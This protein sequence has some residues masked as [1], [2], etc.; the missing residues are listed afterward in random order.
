MDKIER[1]GANGRVYRYM[2]LSELKVGSITFK[3]RGE[4]RYSSS[5]TNRA[6]SWVG[7]CECGNIVKQEYSNIIASKK[8]IDAGLIRVYSC[9]C[10]STLPLGVSAAK[11][12]LRNYEK[13][14]ES[15]GYEFH[16]TFDE[17]LKITKSNCH[18]CDSP[19][20]NSIGRTEKKRG[21]GRY[22]YN[23]MDR[24]NNSVGY[25]LE[26]VVPCC[27]R[28]NRAKDVMGKKQFLEW[29]ERVYKHS[30]KKDSIY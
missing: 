26:N 15:R 29:I 6:V 5:C 16:L 17:F 24:L 1:I 28:C 20:M 25:C 4:T 3:Y 9:G 21:N 11:A 14:A 8:K 22:V 18:Y 23:G 27:R 19:P 2:D 30:I 10:K 7:E 13:S 12:A